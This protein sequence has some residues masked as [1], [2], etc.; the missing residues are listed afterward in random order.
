MNPWNGS[1]ASRRTMAMS[2]LLRCIIQRQN[3]DHCFWF[4]S[5]MASS[6]TK[7]FA[8][9][10][11]SKG[12]KV[13]DQMARVVEAAS[14]HTGSFTQEEVLVAMAGKASRATVFRTLARMVEAGMLRQVQFN[15]RE[16][17]VTAADD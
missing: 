4:A 12:R 17:F 8:D 15:G 11:A 1:P 10:F 14:D 6:P 3:H 5:H 16:V 7:R 13:T 9:F 2:R